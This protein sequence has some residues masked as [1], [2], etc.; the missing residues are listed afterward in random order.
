MEIKSSQ[1]LLE[2]LE[3]IKARIILMEISLLKLEKATRE[4]MEAVRLALKEY[5]E[6]K[7]IPFS[8]LSI[9]VCSF[10]ALANKFRLL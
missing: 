1:K 3:E 5:K 8:K 10:N 4:D 6:G 9:E 2:E 7:T